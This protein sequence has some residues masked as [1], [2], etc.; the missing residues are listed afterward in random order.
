MVVRFFRSF[1]KWY[2]RSLDA[3]P[4]KMNVAMSTIIT[5]AGDGI[6]QYYE[7]YAGWKGDKNSPWEPNT[8]R[9]LS[10]A[11]FG[12]GFIGP[13]GHF[14]YTGLDKFIRK[15]FVVNSVKFIAGKVMLDI[16]MFGP[17]LL[18]FFFGGVTILEGYGWK[19]AREKIENDFV[20]TAI[21]DAAG[22]V[23]IQALNFRFVPVRHHLLVVNVFTFLEDIGLSLAEHNGITWPSWVPQVHFNKSEEESKEVTGPPSTPQPEA[24]AVLPPSTPQSEEEKAHAVPGPSAPATPSNTKSPPPSAST[25]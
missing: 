12:A 20:P 23:P 9:V 19:A 10:M 13:V 24:A 3:H 25:Q 22:W 2:S 5:A 18:L 21:I 7:H 16:T 4:F 14:W 1:G 8:R 11:A 15:H 17:L 6:A